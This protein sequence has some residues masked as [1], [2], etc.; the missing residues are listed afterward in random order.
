MS[1]YSKPT[2]KL[3]ERLYENS[4]KTIIIFRARRK[5]V[6]KQ[7]VVKAYYKI[8][9]PLYSKEFLLLKNINCPSIIKVTGASEDKNC[10]FMEMEYCSSGDLSHCLWP[11]RG[12]NYLEKVI[13][14]VSTQLLIGLKVLHDNGIIHCNLKPSNILIDEFGNAH[15][16]D[17]K[18]AIKV[19]EMTK[20]DVSQY[21]DIISAISL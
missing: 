4:D 5:K 15:I 17:F 16:C 10:F 19:S 21:S 7:I 1:S 18:K 12:C 9:H 20:E 13:K 8:K 14:A 6:I 2:Y 11:N 3:K